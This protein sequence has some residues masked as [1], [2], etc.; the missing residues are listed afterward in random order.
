MDF[1]A[2][3]AHTN[4]KLR[5]FRYC[6]GSLSEDFDLR[7]LQ[8]DNVC[9]LGQWLYGEGGKYAADPHFKTLL[10]MHAALHRCVPPV[11]E[12]VESGQSSAAE[13]L[14]NSRESEFNRLSI[15]MVGL[16]MDFAD[17]HLDA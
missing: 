1:D 9:S 13:A 15:R 7:S 6:R 3:Q 5:L 17:S 14:L 8:K 11:D 2:I 10:A 12:L 16:L 4:W